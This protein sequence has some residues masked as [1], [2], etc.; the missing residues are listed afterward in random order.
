MAGYLDWLDFFTSSLMEIFGFGF[1]F[2]FFT[3]SLIEI[4]GATGFESVR[5]TVLVF[6]SDF[7][8]DGGTGTRLDK[9]T[10]FVF[11][12]NFAGIVSTAGE[13][14]MMLEPLRAGTVLP[15]SAGN[16]AGAFGLRS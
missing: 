12:S 2:A 8:H 13:P 6:G 10:V 3:S 11:G 1:V 9:S 4:F 15:K 7:F 16:G 14:A 5:S